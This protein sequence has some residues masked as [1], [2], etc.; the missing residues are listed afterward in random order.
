M[1]FL[2][3]KRIFV[4]KCFRCRGTGRIIKEEDYRKSSY[5]RLICPRCGGTGKTPKIK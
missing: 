2:I 4:I 5:K 1:N 3:R